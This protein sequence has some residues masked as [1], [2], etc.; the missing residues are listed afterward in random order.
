MSDDS[1]LKKIA[2]NFSELSE[3]ERQMMKKRFGIEMPRMPTLEEVQRA[4]AKTRDKLR[5]MDERARAQHRKP[6]GTNDDG[7]ASP[8]D[9]PKTNS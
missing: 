4:F 7:G 5:E 3:R 2:N 1:L 9:S 8:A 6:P